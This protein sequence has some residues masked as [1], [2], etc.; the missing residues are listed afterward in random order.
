[1]P[2]KRIFISLELS[3]CNSH[4]TILILEFTISRSGTLTSSFVSLAIVSFSYALSRRSKI[5]RLTTRLCS[6]DVDVGVGV[7]IG[8]GVPLALAIIASINQ[9]P[10]GEL[11]SQI[12]LRRTRSGSRFSSPR[13]ESRV[14]ICESLLVLFPVTF[15][16]NQFM[17]VCVCVYV[18]KRN[19]TRHRICATFLASGNLRALFIFHRCVLHECRGKETICLAFQRLWSFSLSLARM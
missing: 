5:D 8:V 19:W 11:V 1:M 4:A 15:T 7:G 18:T 17:S 9:L 10:R 13:R 6:A 14:Y 2:R 16:I 3:A 12:C